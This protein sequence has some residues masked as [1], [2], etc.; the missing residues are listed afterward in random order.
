MTAAELILLQ[1]K[2]VAYILSSF[3]PIFCFA[4]QKETQTYSVKP[5]ISKLNI[6][7][8]QLGEGN[9]EDIDSYRVR[10]CVCVHTDCKITVH[11]QNEES[12]LLSQ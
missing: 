6:S 4:I 12:H 3:R 5:L 8:L 10:A 7:L 11:A 2:S 9:R 1:K